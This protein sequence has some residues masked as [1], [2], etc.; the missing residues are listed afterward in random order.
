LVT[1]YPQPLFEA[2]GGS[3]AGIAA[4]AA[5]AAL[6]PIAWHV[7]QRRLVLIAATQLSFL[8]GGMLALFLARPVY[9]V[10]AVDRFDLVAARDI[11]ARD[12]AEVKRDEFRRRPLDGP[13]YVAAVLP[14]TPRDRQRILDA[15]LEG[16]DLQRFPQQYVPYQDEV[17]N[18]LARA[19]PLASVHARDPAAFDRALGALGRQRESV[20]VL[21]LRAKNRDGVVLLDAASGAPLGIL[22]VEPW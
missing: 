20:R 19:K 6:G 15:S 2:G 17:R 11:S 1:W 8:L 12:L 22:L 3:R 5:A 13:K 21:P 16:K 14:D 4:V 9:L 10:F 18:V 7:L